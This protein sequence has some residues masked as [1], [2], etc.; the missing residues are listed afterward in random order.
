MD[1]KLKY[2][3]DMGKRK[4][5]EEILLNDYGCFDDFTVDKLL[6]LSVV[7]RSEQLDCVDCDYVRIND[8]CI[9]CRKCGDIKDV[10]I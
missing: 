6:D 8:N 5:I 9:E 1:I 7:G 3:S 2:S 4:Q 10:A